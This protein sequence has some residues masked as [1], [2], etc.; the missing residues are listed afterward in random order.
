M[1]LFGFKR[2]FCRFELLQKPGGVRDVGWAAEQRH[3]SQIPY[4][5][6]FYPVHSPTA[7]P[8]QARAVLE[9]EVADVLRAVQ[10]GDVVQVLAF[11]AVRS[12]P[13]ALPPFFATEVAVA[14]Q[15]V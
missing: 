11:M 15:N 2:G 10:V 1:A 5:H 12:W 8:V 13:M 3:G 7:G 14:R 9:L 6:G 4:C